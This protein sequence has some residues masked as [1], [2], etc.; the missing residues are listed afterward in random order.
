MLGYQVAPKAWETVYCRREPT[1]FECAYRHLDL[2]KPIFEY[3]VNDEAA[4]DFLVSGDW[5]ED[6]SEVLATHVFANKDIPKGSY[7]MPEHLASSLVM[8]R[9]TV[10]GLKG[11][12][13]YG[14]VAIIED[15]VEFVQDYGHESL[16]EGSGQVLVEVGASYLI[17]EVGTLE[18]ANV[19]RWVPSH[20]TGKRP[21]YSPVYERH[22]HSFDVFMVALKDIPKGTELLKYESM[23]DE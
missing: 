21:K 4:G 23:W 20:P 5:S 7:I 10:K 8:S 3:N 1:P 11:N 2:T 17:K 18:E 22:R 13:E 12:L 15:F 16:S 6:G 9:E 19:G 14:G